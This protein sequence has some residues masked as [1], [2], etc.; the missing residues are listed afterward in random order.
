MWIFGFRGRRFIGRDLGFGTFVY[1]VRIG[2]YLL[3][4]TFVYNVHKGRV[5]SRDVGG[6]VL[7]SCFV[8]FKLI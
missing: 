4:M 2:L 5:F 6:G 8:G 1:F 3:K 7:G